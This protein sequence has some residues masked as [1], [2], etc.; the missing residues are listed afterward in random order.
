MVV[1]QSLIVEWAIVKVLYFYIRKKIKHHK[2]F[3]RVLSRSWDVFKSVFEI[4]GTFVFIDGDE[5][6]M[7]DGNNFLQLKR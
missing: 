6:N 2:I 4:H 5:K 7:V 1:Q 3:E